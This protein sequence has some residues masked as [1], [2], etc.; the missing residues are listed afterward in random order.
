MVNIKKNNINLKEFLEYIY[1]INS[2]LSLN[3][4]INVNIE[5]QPY[6]TIMRII[7]LF[8]TEYYDEIINNKKIFI[9]IIKNIYKK[10]SNKNLDDIIEDEIS[11]LL[12]I[13][14]TGYNYFIMTDVQK[15]IDKNS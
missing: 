1:N 3:E 14:V 11:N 7:N 9:N 15:I 8:Y 2:I 10:T 5:T 12:N 13:N 4:Y 6:I